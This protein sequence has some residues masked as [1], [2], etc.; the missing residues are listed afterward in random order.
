MTTLRP[1]QQRCI[2]EARQRYIQGARSI[3]IVAPTGAGKTI[4]GAEIARRA[5]GKVLWLAHRHELVDQAKEKLPADIPVATIQGLLASGQRPEADILVWDEVHHAVADEWG[6]L[7]A[8]YRGALRIGLTATP[9]RSDGRPLG[10]VCDA[11]VVAASYSELMAGGYIVDCDVFAPAKGKTLAMTVPEAVDTYARGKQT[12]V[13]CDLVASAQK[14]SAEI[15][16]SAVIHADTDHDTRRDLVTR[17]RAGDL[18]VLLNVYVLSE[19][20]DAPNAEVCVL[21]VSVGH[22]SGYLQ[23]V[24]RVLRPFPGKERARIVDLVGSSH[25]HGHPTIDRE[26]SLEGQA[27]RRKGK[28]P[29]LWQCK[30]C[31]WVTGAQPK[32]RKC[33]HCGKKIPEPEAIR[34]ARRKMKRQE[35]YARTTADQRE[36]DYQKLLGVAKARGYKLGWAK[37]VY[38][39]RYGEWPG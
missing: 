29:V 6:K 22:A 15:P 19:G 31:G 39:S 26:Y 5:R 3:C 10:D 11:L 25:D 33:V 7:M 9:E 2:D 16:S 37:H 4:I 17:F 38:H 21:G 12:I 36:A 34:T 8:D 32:D 23:R 24:G 35:K 30:Y 18:Q 28:A 1:Y 27:I 20:F 13:F 14:A